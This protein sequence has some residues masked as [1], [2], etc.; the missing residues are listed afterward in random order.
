[1]TNDSDSIIGTVILWFIAAVGISVLLLV[2]FTTS[3]I[4]YFLLFSSL[5]LVILSTIFLFLAMKNIRLTDSD[6][7]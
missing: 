6:F 5:L 2:S 3:K 1:M 4:L 7:W